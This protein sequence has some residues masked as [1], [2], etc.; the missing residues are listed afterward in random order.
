MTTSDT[1]SRLARAKEFILSRKTDLFYSES[2]GRR[3]TSFAGRWSDLSR[4]VDF[5]TDDQVLDIGCAEGLIA[6]EV[7]PRV[8][9]V[10]AFD[11]SETRVSEAQ[12][13]AAERGITNVCFEV[14]SVDTYPLTPLSYDVTL[15]LAV[16]G[17]R[18][19]TERR[20]GPEHLVRILD[21]TRRQLL[22]R[23]GMQNEAREE[24]RVGEILDVCDD[25]GFD[26]LCF[27]R[28]RRGE[29]ASPNNLVVAN[30]RGSDARSGQLPMLTL[31]PTAHLTDHPAV[32]SAAS[33]FSL[34]DG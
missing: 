4:V 14:A 23:V 29:F 24:A 27:S 3:T 21:A 33:I 10:D 11:V 31:V 32:R 9:R 12:R 30:R 8:A 7:A 2:D 19:D 5:R 25:R 20:V 13:L 15:F 22:M 34:E 16:Y 17:K 6:L 18:I 1:M 28:T 26:A